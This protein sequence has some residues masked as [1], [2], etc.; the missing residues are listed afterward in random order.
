[1]S[2]ASVSADQVSSD[3]A[4]CLFLRFMNSHLAEKCSFAAL[5]DIGST[6]ARMAHSGHPS[7]TLPSSRGSEP[8][9]CQHVRDANG[10]WAARSVSLG[11]YLVPPHHCNS[12]ASA[13]LSQQHSGTHACSVSPLGH[14]VLALPLPG[15][16]RTGPGGTRRWDGGVLSPSGLIVR[17][18]LH[19]AARRW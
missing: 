5:F 17:H 3:D 15:S 2:S 14:T 16:T 19:R 12:I 8:L 18:L 10:G 4:M 6:A 9:N 11:V 1:M 13:P 7:H